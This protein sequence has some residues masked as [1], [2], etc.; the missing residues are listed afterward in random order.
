MVNFERQMNLLEVFSY[1]AELAEIAR[2]HS[3]DTALNDY[4]EHENLAGQTV[5]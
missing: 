4:F 3:K 1:D 2:A 5:A